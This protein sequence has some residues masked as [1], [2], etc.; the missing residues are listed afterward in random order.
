MLVSGKNSHCLSAFTYT[1]SDPAG[2]AA[3]AI[4][5]VSVVEKAQ[6]IPVVGYQPTS[7]PTQQ[8]S[9]RPAMPVTLR[10]TVP[11]TRRPTVRPSKRPSPDDVATPG[12]CAELCFDP[13]EPDRCPLCDPLTLPSCSDPSLQLGDVCESDGDCG[14][15]DQLNNCEGTFD[16]YRRVA[17]VDRPSECIPR[18]GEV[19]VIHA[20]GDTSVTSDQPESVLGGLDF[21]AV[22]ESPKTDG[23]VQFKLSDSVCECVT[24]KRATLKLY[25]I[26]QSRSGGFVHVMN[27]YWKESETSWSNAPDASGPPLVQIGYALENDWIEVDVTELVNNSDEYVA[28]RIE[29]CVKNRVEYAS[30]EYLQGQY[31]PKVNRISRPVTIYETYS[32]Q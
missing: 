17:C 27:P 31:A 15:N 23:L 10:P 11:L 7:R 24:I 21:F 16:V 32:H 13:V 6:S 29:A 30:K 1:I 12:L 18:E 5:I 3:S 22:D 14:L 28:M 8:P 4:V 2:N 26:N 20:H 9:M 19:I 25:V